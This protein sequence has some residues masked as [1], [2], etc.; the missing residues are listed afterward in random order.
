MTLIR[1]DLR[2]AAVD[3]LRAAG[4]AAGPNV[5]SSRAWP[6]DPKALPVIQAVVL[7]D[8][9]ESWGR[10]APGFTRTAGLLVTAKFRFDGP[11]DFERQS[12]LLC[13]Q[14]ELAIMGNVAL[15]AMIQQVSAIDSDLA[16]D[17]LGAVQVGVVRI[18]FD[19]EYAQTFA[20]PSEPLV[21]I[22]ATV[23]AGL[24]AP[25]INFETDFLQPEG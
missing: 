25:P 9:A 15:Q 2:T 7:A 8:T 23:R 6:T 19:L 12:D 4:T 20:P 24:D 16:S 17:A 11:E 1:A 5:F 10:N 21:S 22:A 14:I 18:R 3:A 13:E